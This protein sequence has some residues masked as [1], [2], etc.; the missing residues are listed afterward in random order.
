MVKEAWR[1]AGWS[2]QAGESI[3]FLDELPQIRRDEEKP[4]GR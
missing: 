3:S 2:D 1:G 4:G